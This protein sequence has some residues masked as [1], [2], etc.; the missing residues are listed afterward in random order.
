MICASSIL[1]L[2]LI[3]M[4]MFYHDQLTKEGYATLTKILLV[5][6][7]VGGYYYLPYPLTAYGLNRNSMGRV[8]RESLLIGSGLLV[9]S[10]GFRYFL[11]SIGVEEMRFRFSIT[12]DILFYPVFAFLQEIITKGYFQ[13]YLVGALAHRR[14]NKVL[15]VL[16][17]SVLFALTHLIHGYSVFTGL[18]IFSVFTGWYYER[19]RNIWGVTII[20]TILG[21][22]LFYFM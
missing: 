14:H 5:G 10:I 19:S 11:I 1:A 9:F 16:I 21:W 2:S 12:G 3:S 17:S 13:S 4:Y 20:H 6:L 18:F 7:F 15:A 22:S 8:L